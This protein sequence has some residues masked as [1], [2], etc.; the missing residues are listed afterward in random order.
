[1]ETKL[2][3]SGRVLNGWI[4][5]PPDVR[6]FQYIL[7]AKSKDIAPAVDL[8]PGCSAVEDQSN[9]GSCVHNAL[10]GSLEFLEVKNKEPFV[11]KSRLF[12]YYC[13]RADMGATDK[14]TGDTIRH[15]CQ[16]LNKFGTCDEKLWPYDISQFKVKPPEPCYTDAIQHIITSYWAINSIDEIR[17]CLTEGFPVAFGTLLFLQFEIVGKDGIVKNPGCW[18]KIKPIGGHAMLIVG[19]DDSVKRFIVRNSWGTGWG[20]EGYCYISYDYIKKYASDFWTV[21]V[22]K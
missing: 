2:G 3:K 7:K 1:M 22:E 19:H 11:D 15:G 10:V 9:L 16:M 8:R 21:R 14:D 17:Q 13:S 4:P 12:S 5:Q 6:D 20:D 18:S